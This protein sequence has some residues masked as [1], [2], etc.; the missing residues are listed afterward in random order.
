MFKFL[1]LLNYCIYFKQR[2]AETEA[3]AECADDAKLRAP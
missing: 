2:G 3:L 1:I